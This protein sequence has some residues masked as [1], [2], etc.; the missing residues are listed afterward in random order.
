M[1]PPHQPEPSSSADSMFTPK[2]EEKS[3]AFLPVAIAAV[4]VAV[5]VAGSVLLSRRHA[6]A[7]LPTTLQ[8][9]AAYAPNLPLTGIQMSESGSLS[10][11]KTTYIEGHVA[12]HGASTVTGAIVQVVLAND[13]ELA[14]QIQTLPLTLIRMRQPYVDT[15]PI[16]ASPLAPGAEADFRLI[17]DPLNDNWNQQQPEIRVIQVTTK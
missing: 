14:P 3:F 17:L 2:A 6:A 11:V 16:S 8:P 4:V 12:N 5:I 7:P 9:A 15:A 1:P 10:G 13:V